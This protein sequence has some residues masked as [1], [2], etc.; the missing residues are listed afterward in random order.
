MLN[1]SNK[2]RNVVVQGLGFVGSAMAIAI[3]SKL[4]NKGEALFNVVGVDLPSNEGQKR[5]NAINSAEF[6]FLTSDK[7]INIELKRSISRGNLIAT[8]DLNV[9]A[10]ANI[11][12]VSINCDL[13]IVEGQEQ[14]DLKNFKQSVGEIAHHIPEG[15]LLIIESTVPPGTCEKII[16]PMIKDI[17]EKRSLNIDNFCLAHSYE[18]VMPGKKIIL[19]QSLIF[20]ESFLEL[21]KNLK[22]NVEEFLSKVINTDEYPLTCLQNTI[23][24]E[25]GK[26]LENSYRAV[27][28]AFMEEW[29]RFAEHTGIDIYKI[30]DAIRMRPT[31]S[32]MRQPG[33]GVGGY[34]LTKDPLFARIAARD[35]FKID[36]HDF[37]FSSQSVNINSKMPKVTFRKIEEYFKGKIKGKR[38]LL[39]GATYRP[40]IGDT[41]SSPSEQFA[42]D[43]LL[44]NGKLM[45]CDPLIN[46]WEEMQLKIE[47]RIPNFSNFDV[48]VF[49]VQHNEFK[50]IDFKDLLANHDT[51]IFDA[52]NVLTKYQIDL[53]IRII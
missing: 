20:G 45:V 10:S 30:I 37:P 52:N 49:A 42:R 13:T 38:F 21:I 22:K 48:V 35:I 51:L 53:L 50:K 34:C 19:V 44:S 18:R 25:T 16:Y 26:I 23:A 7:N 28:I 27:N 31:H 24:S 1:I 39:M 41:R 12:L 11:V 15:T 9:Y 29:G 36:G 6:P 43:V 3:S 32:N 2:A 33:F 47:T 8:S 40:N 46:F 17:F 4:N 14:V 5:I